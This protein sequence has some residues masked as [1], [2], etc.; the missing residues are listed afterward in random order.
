VFVLFC[1]SIEYVRTYHYR[2]LPI[3]YIVRMTSSFC[4]V[5]SWRIVPT[6]VIAILFQQ[7]TVFVSGSYSITIGSTGNSKGIDYC[8]NVTNILHCSTPRHKL[9]IATNHKSLEAS[10]LSTTS[11]TNT[12]MSKRFE[13]NFVYRY[14]NGCCGWRTTVGARRVVLVI[15]SGG[16][17]DDDDDYNEK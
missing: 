7:D 4:F 10:S 14:G 11:T 13:G 3:A 16:N 2:V 6:I 8:T 17:D 9:D 1:A 5:R 12:S 15:F